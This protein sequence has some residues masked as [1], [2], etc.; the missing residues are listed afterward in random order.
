MGIIFDTQSLI[1]QD[2]IFSV[3]IFSCQGKHGY[4][5]V[6]INIFLLLL[7]N[8]FTN[9]FLNNVSVEINYYDYDIIVVVFSVSAT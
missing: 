9:L 7:L 8:S 5:D 3:I 2:D 4:D 1:S 6:I